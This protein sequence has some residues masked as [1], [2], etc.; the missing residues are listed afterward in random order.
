MMVEN[1]REAPILNPLLLVI[2]TDELR[3]RAVIRNMSLNQTASDP[4]ILNGF[5][6]IEA[7]AR[8]AFAKVAAAN[9]IA[10]P[11]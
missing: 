5:G 9:L 1:K 8:S 10:S 6:K 4:R 7:K 3:Q 11:C 2:D